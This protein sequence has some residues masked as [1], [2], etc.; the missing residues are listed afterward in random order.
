MMVVPWLQ[1]KMIN[2]NAV[3][4]GVHN[5]LF[6]NLSNILICQWLYKNGIFL[7]HLVA[8]ILDIDLSQRVHPLN[9]SLNRTLVLTFRWWKL[10]VDHLNLKDRSDQSAVNISLETYI[11]MILPASSALNLFLDTQLR[12]SILSFCIF[13]NFVITYLKNLTSV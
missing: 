6:V 2:Q 1:L 9:I 3:V 13:L 10:S 8:L 4:F 7:L 5:R 12:T 11:F